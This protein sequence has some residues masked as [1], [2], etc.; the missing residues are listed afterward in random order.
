MFD[1]SDQ[2][3]CDQ[4]EPL[5]TRSISAS[6]LATG[7]FTCVLAL[8]LYGCGGSKGA[9]PPNDSHG[10]SQSRVKLTQPDES[11]RLP[12]LERSPTL[13]GIDMNGNG[14]RDDIDAYIEQNFPVAAEKKATLQLAR[15]LQQALLVDTTAGEALEA[16]SKASVRALKCAGR[17]FSGPDGTK[18]MLMMSEELEALTT[19]TK[20]RLLAYLE[21]N[22]ARSG[23]VLKLPSGDTC[24]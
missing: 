16:I 10:P 15:S 8:L 18:R 22:K 19:N 5:K 6:S 24:D 3:E 4:E 23:S 13:Q 20:I 14:V 17:V 1:T 12:N 9:P 21:F 2:D 11:N 7:A